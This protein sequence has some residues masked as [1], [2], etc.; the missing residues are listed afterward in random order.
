MTIQADNFYD[1]ICDANG[2]ASCVTLFKVPFSWQQNAIYL[3]DTIL[4]ILIIK[5]VQNDSRTR[6]T[7]S[8]LY[9]LH[10]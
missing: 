4:N 7:Q 8:T 2:I 6:L 5:F 10:F 3:H 9:M 1:I